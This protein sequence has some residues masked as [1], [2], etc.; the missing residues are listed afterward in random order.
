MMLVGTVIAQ[1][2]D[3][4]T[5]KTNIASLSQNYL[6]VRFDFSE[7]SEWEG[8]TKVAV[9]TQN[10]KGKVYHVL[11]DAGGIVTVPSEVL[12]SSS[13]I[14]VGVFG[15]DGD[16]L[17][18]T[19]N[20]SAIELVEGSYIPST[21]AE[22]PTPDIYQQVLAELANRIS[23]APNDGREYVR[24][25]SSWVENTGGSADHAAL[26][27]LDYEDSGHRG[28]ASEQEVTN[29]N[30]NLST[31]SDNVDTIVDGVQALNK[32]YFGDPDAAEQPEIDGFRATTSRKLTELDSGI[33]AASDTAAT[34]LSTANSA[35][36]ATSGAQTTADTALANAATAQTTADGKVTRITAGAG[37][38]VNNTTP[39]TPVVSANTSTVNPQMNG[40]AS[41]GSGNTLA[42]ANHVHPTDASRA[43]ALVLG[44][45][46]MTGSSALRVVD[47]GLGNNFTLELTPTTPQFASGGWGEVGSAMADFC[48]LTSEGHE[49]VF[50]SQNL[51]D[52][53]R[54]DIIRSPSAV[55][56]SVP[57]G[58]TYQVGANTNSELFFYYRTNASRNYI[59]RIR[60]IANSSNATG[61][62][63]VA[64]SLATERPTV[65]SSY[66]APQMSFVRGR[67]RRELLG[68]FNTSDNARTFSLSTNADG[69]PVGANTRMRFLIEASG[70]IGVSGGTAGAWVNENIS[71]SIALSIELDSISFAIGNI[72]APHDKI[73]VEYHI[74]GSSGTRCR[75]RVNGEEWRPWQWLLG[76]TPDAD[77]PL[78]IRATPLIAVSSALRVYLL[79]RGDS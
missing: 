74:Q 70:G 7:T 68:T 43:Q 61:T 27:N 46:S 64:M 24:K 67:S 44:L 77:R 29:V 48:V 14:L 20:L 23:E 52:T 22:P 38:S 28:F 41:P 79:Q 66:Q 50:G 57:S 39:T 3:V 37:M 16:S 75:V 56:I 36:G 55:N 9:F 21:G 33:A 32:D 11:V 12:Q 17:R 54:L 4:T 62:S 59:A 78:M 15:T 35:S 76:V 45:S 34:A 71:R 58:A 13:R 65:T 31:L 49:L 2:L 5:P 72:S 18:V 1:R 8:L 63:S 47:G 73:E 19:T 6:S 26:E 25:D 69:T 42:L 53:L 51:N 10:R 40:V 60:S 30:D